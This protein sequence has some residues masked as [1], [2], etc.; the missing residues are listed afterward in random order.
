MYAFFS[1]YPNVHPNS[2]PLHDASYS[3]RHFSVLTGVLCVGSCAAKLQ[4]YLCA[5][6]ASAC[7]Y[8]LLTR[9]SEANNRGKDE[10]RGRGKHE[11]EERNAHFHGSAL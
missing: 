6:V 10:G 8:C 11:D 1:L 2:M 3:T 5:L 4:M 9:P 7:P